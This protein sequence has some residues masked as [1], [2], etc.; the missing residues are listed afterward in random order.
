M[1]LGGGSWNGLG[2][3]LGL[4]LGSQGWLGRQAGP[5]QGADCGPGA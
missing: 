3:G 4:A 2:V 1:S 5:S